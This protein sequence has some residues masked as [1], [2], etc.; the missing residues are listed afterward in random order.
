VGVLNLPARIRWPNDIIL[1]GRKFSGILVERTQPKR[2]PAAF[3]LGV[4][5]NVNSQPTLKDAT[6]L[7]VV[8]GAELDRLSLVRELLRSLDGWFEEVSRGHTELVG[9]HW[10][11]FSSTLGTR[12]TIVRG[13]ARFTGR[14]VDISHRLGVTLELDDGLHMTFRGEQVTVEH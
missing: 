11:R 7:A 10:R 8:S 12:I 13:R 5:I 1:A 14:V 6:S 3:I 9:N 4:G 2:Y